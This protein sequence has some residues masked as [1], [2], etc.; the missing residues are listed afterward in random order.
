MMK[1]LVSV[2]IVSK[3]RKDDLVECLNF[4]KKSSYKNLELIV[5]DNAS[6]PPLLTWLP[7]RY[8]NI[9]LI[10]S[11]ENLGAAQ[12]RNRGLAEAK[13]EYIIFSDDDAYP[14]RD[15][16]K[17]LVEVFRKN[18]KAG[19]VQPL[20]YDKNKKN[21]LQGAGHD[22][23]LLTGRIKAWGVQERDIGQYEGIR[24]V[25]MCGCVWMVKREV[26][27]KIGDYDEDYFIPYEDS[28]FSI[29]AR[30][31]GFKLY[32]YSKAK[33]Y[34]QGI[35]KTFI[36]P[37]IE[38]LGI[39]SKERAFRVARNKIIFMTKHS[40]FPKNFF[41]FLLLLPTYIFTH[42]IIIL[43]AGRF[44]ILSNYWSGIFSGLMYLFRK[45][46]SGPFFL[47]MAWQEPYAWLINKSSKTILDVGCGDGLPMKLIKLR[48]KFKKTVGI[49]IFEPYIRKA[50]NQRIHD[51]YIVTDIN[52]IPLGNMSFDTVM[53]FQVLEHLSKNDAWKLL[54][55]MEK[56]AKKQVII[57]SPIGEMHH[58]A[59]DKNPYQVHRSLFYPEEFEKRGYRVTKFGRKGILGENGIVHKTKN[60]ILRKLIYFFNFVLTPVLY[61]IPS[62]NDYHFYA[63]KDMKK[64]N[65]KKL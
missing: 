11:D 29:R 12:G 22:I 2:V 60:N 35:K 47:L 52:K 19:I 25:P 59:I 24:E 53:A 57:S 61:L 5:V 55:A 23:N 56:I 17:S 26:F 34:H 21:F 16:V 54:T 63:F 38:W 30:K 33:T 58:P 15:M 10:T 49:D 40:P 13:G 41:F 20:V 32:C 64:K 36:H 31:A 9:K 4:Y 14:E 43:L 28:D 44:D 39:T 18:K 1:N 7:K 8:K 51:E 45:T 46:F 27:Q 37:W 6:R 62:V 50:R 65:I 42:S 48:R 3:D